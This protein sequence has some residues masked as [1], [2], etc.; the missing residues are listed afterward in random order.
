MEVVS[1]IQRPEIHPVLSWSR[2]FTDDFKELSQYSS[3]AFSSCTII[4]KSYLIH[5]DSPFMLYDFLFLNAAIYSH[6]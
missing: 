1:F 2:A 5:W 6:V 4:Q 3:N